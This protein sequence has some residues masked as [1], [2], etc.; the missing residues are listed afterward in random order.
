MVSLW[1]LAAGRVVGSPKSC[2]MESSFILLGVVRAAEKLGSH[3]GLVG[4]QPTDQYRSSDP[5][6]NRK[7]VEIKR[8]PEV[9][10]GR[11]FL[12]LQ[13][14][15]GRVSHSVDRVEEADYTGRVDQS[16]R[17]QRRHQG[18]ARSRE[19]ASP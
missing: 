14:D 4:L 8:H 2:S 13:R 7:A 9:G 19:R 15:P 3:F 12:R 17:T 16:Q 5:V 10:A 6:D 18:D 11:R 1:L